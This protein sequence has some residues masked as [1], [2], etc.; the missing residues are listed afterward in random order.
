MRIPIYDVRLGQRRLHQLRVPL[1]EPLHYIRQL[2]RQVCRLG[3][4]GDD[5]ARQTSEQP[6]TMRSQIGD[7]SHSL[8]Q[9]AALHRLC[10]AAVV[11]RVIHAAGHVGLAVRSAD[12]P[13]RSLSNTKQREH[14]R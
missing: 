8:V 2:G 13:A 9:A 12:K 14:F 1:L 4:I 11:L 6:R 10:V 7:A 3:R 5:A